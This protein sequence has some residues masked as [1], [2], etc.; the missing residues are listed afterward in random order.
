MTMFWMFVIVV[1]TVYSAGLF[2]NRQNYEAERD[3]IADRQT[4]STEVE[5]FPADPSTPGVAGAVAGFGLL[6]GWVVV[7]GVMLYR[8]QRAKARRAVEVSD[9]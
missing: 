3:R 1:V 4:S 2:V 7:G 6:G 9:R 5:S 8:A